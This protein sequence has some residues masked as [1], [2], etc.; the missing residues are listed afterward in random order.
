M[1]TVAARLPDDDVAPPAGAAAADRRCTGA[2]ASPLL[3]LEA[4]RSRA[5]GPTYLCPGEA[6]PISRAVHLA[7]LAAFYPRCRDCPHCGDVGGLPRPQPDPIALRIPAA[8]SLVPPL[9][10]LVGLA[11]PAREASGVHSASGGEP[12]GVSV[13][14]GAAESPTTAVGLR[15]GASPSGIEPLVVDAALSRLIRRDGIRGVHRNE[16]T[17]EIAA[18]FA[19]RL[20]RLAWRSIPRRGRHWDDAAGP[21]HPA[22]SPIVVVGRDRRPASP[23]IAAGVVPA[24]LRM[25][26]QVVDLGCV[27]RPAIDF[28]V[29]HLRAA[30]GIH[31][32]GSGCPPAWVGLDIIGPDGVPWSAGGQLADWVAPDAARGLRPTRQGGSLRTVAIEV[33]QRADFQRRLPEPGR[34]RFGVASLCPIVRR[35]LADWFGPAGDGVVELSERLFPP[36]GGEATRDQRRQLRQELARAGLDAAI[37]IGDDGRLVRLFDEQGR[38]AP[39]TAW[40]VRLVE[41]QQASS[42]VA[43]ARVVLAED[44]SP[45]ARGRLQALGVEA[46]VAPPDH[47]SLVSRLLA[48]QALLA[49]DGVGRIWQRDH[50]PVCDGMVTLAELLKLAARTGGPVSHWAH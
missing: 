26:C 37:V 18:R 29:Y 30:A 23:D 19:E 28:G 10:N 3:Q 46:L 38:Q 15:L 36:E 40:L 50:Y 4:W 14:P 20:G 44:V 32:A 33:L 16:L 17:R 48:S 41:Q 2:S 24:L 34:A 21:A 8:G 11:A 27:S 12:S 9:R 6:A 47:E 31:L 1:E 5:A 42:G 13:L 22:A 43:V 35:A 7:R 25:G 39:A 45:L 49:A